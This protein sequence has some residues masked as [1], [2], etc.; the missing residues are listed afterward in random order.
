MKFKKTL[1]KEQ[2]LKQEKKRYYEKV[3]AL[4]EGRLSER[5]EVNIIEQLIENKEVKYLSDKTQRLIVQFIEKGLIT[6]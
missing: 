3:E 4:E 6:I 2:K 5:G 1:T